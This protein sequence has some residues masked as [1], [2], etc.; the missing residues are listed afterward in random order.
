MEAA[1]RVFAGE[2]A[3]AVPAEGGGAVLLPSGAVCRF[4]CIAGALTEVTGDRGGMLEARVADPTGAFRLITGRGDDEVN[5]SLEAITPPAFVLAWGEAVFRLTP[6]GGDLVVQ[7]D[8]VVR[9]DR[10]ARDAWVLRTALLTIER[11]KKQYAVTPE[12]ADTARQLAAMVAR[13]LET[14]KP[15]VRCNPAEVKQTVE[16]L[17]SRGAGRQGIAVEEL[18]RQCAE[19]GISR[20]EVDGAIR[21]LFED[22]DCY[23][24]QKGLIKLL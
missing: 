13:A 5:E 10:E 15:Q 21:Q 9:I 20:D 12:S 19:G 2:L 17:V 3:M 18:Y 7:P 22:G 4:I 23:F 6:G 11:L 24:P 14:A 16:E 1:C 8:S